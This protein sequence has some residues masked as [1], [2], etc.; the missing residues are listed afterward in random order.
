MSPS[1]ARNIEVV[2]KYF[3]GCNSGDID[4]LMSTLAPD[5]TH[6]FLPSSFP[7]IKGADH[8]AKY[9]RKYKQALNPVWAIDRI[10]AQGD[11]VVSE[12]SC[13]W[14]APKTG[15]RLMAR[16]SEWYVMRDAKILEVR[17]YFIA[18]TDSSTELATFPYV[19]RGYLPMGDQG[20]R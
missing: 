2:G 5:V 14:T 20:I 17:A 3:D 11:E 19:E 7:P 16:G 1:E 10:M 12:W 9:W 13:I 4:D 8:L 15:K 6:Y 18:S